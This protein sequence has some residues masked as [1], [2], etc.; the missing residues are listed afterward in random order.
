MTIKNK[1]HNNHIGLKS[2]FGN[3]ILLLN[4]KGYDLTPSPPFSR[5]LY[6]EI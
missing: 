6:P 5:T 4:K 3:K 1:D 2:L